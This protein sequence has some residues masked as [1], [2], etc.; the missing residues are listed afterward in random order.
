MPSSGSPQSAVSFAAEDRVGFEGVSS[1]LGCEGD[2]DATILQC[3]MTKS[4]DEILNKTSIFAKESGLLAPFGARVDGNF[5]PRSPVELAADEQYVQDS[6]MGD[7]DIIMGFNNQEGGFITVEFEGSPLEG[8]SNAMVFMMLL[9]TSIKLF[10]NK[11]SDELVSK[12]VDFFYR[13]ADFGSNTSVVVQ[14]MV[15][16]YGD[17]LMYAPTY[18]WLRPMVAQTHAGKRYLYIFEHEFSFNEHK[19]HGS[20][21]GDELFVEFDITL[22]ED[23]LFNQI[24]KTTAG[25]NDN[26]HKMG[27]LFVSI[28]TTFAKTGD[29]NPA[30]KDVLG[31]DWPEF[32][33]EDEAVLSLSLP[34]H[35][36][37]DV[38]KDRIALWV[39]LV[40]EIISAK[41][42]Q[43]KEATSTEGATRDEL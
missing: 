2:T 43:K 37:R 24:N 33:S 31:S 18:E 16:L 41:Q 27:D 35:V 40:P 5:I 23:S 17:A 3:L 4:T 20:H 22:P 15:N 11:K 29:P 7:V 19:I 10:N 38:M 39:K 42:R 12:V 9:D 28:I 36:L 1:K 26:D 14:D 32:T 34:P 21:H 30:L 8:F 6:G 25:C 13:R